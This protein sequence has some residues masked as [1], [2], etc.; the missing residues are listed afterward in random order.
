MKLDL[1]I[2]IPQFVHQMITHLCQQDFPFQLLIRLNDPHGKPGLGY[3]LGHIGIYEQLL[4]VG[5]CFFQQY[6]KIKTVQRLVV[7]KTCG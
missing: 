6:G 2:F 5:G 1:V 3:I 7:V 4:D